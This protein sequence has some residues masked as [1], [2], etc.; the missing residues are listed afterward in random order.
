MRLTC[1]LPHNPNLLHEQLLAAFPAAVAAIVAAH[2]PAGESANQARRGRIR[3]LAEGA[4]GTAVAE[5]TLAEV[6]ALL[7]VLL[8]RAGALDDSLRVRPLDEWV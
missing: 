3:Q 2:D 4:V 5:L 7:A 6:H 8:W 1:T